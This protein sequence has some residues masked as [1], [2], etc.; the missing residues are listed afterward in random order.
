MAAT[1]I[2]G[3]SSLCSKV[4]ESKKEILGQIEAVQRNASLVAER[5]SERMRCLEARLGVVRQLNDASYL[6]SKPWSYDTYKRNRDEAESTCARTTTFVPIMLS[7]HGDI[8]RYLPARGLAFL[9]KLPSDVYALPVERSVLMDEEIR[10][11]VDR[12]GSFYKLSTEKKTLVEASII[13]E[14]KAIG[15]HEG[16]VILYGGDTPDLHDMVK[17]LT[18]KPKLS[19]PGSP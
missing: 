19:A 1:G 6:D 3:S 2:G 9:D 7:E 12:A 4:D 16:I 18:L 14:S 10:V 15:D 5:Q 11:V 8:L 13:A 17:E